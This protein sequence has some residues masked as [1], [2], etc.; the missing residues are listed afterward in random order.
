MG[1]KAVLLAL[2]LL[3]QGLAG[4]HAV[5]HDAVSFE[6]NCILCQHAEDSFVAG[7]ADNPTT[8][9]IYSDEYSLDLAD[10]VLERT[11]HNLPMTRAPPQTA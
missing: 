9:T 6:E 1:L 8:L 3:M 5:A 7:P 2:F 11:I 4:S 10:Q